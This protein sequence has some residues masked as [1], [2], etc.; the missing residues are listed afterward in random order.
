VC[1]APVY[2]TGGSLAWAIR[3]EACDSSTT[4]EVVARLWICAPAPGACGI[5][6]E[7]R[8]GIAD[9]R[10]C[11]FFFANLPYPYLQVQNW[12]FTYFVD[13]FGTDGT[14]N[15]PVD[16]RAVRFASVRQVSPPPAAATFGDVP[17]SHPFFRHVEALADSHISGGCG[18]G[19]FCPDRPLTRGE[20]AVMLAEALGLNFP[21]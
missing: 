19:L 16:F 6:G 2:L 21:E 20:F 14:S 15:V 7:V 18:N 11:N 5:A 4:T 8:S 9:A 10:G 12:N 17:P 13:V 1:R 3:L